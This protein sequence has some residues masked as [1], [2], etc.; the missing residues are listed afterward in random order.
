MKATRVSKVIVMVA[1][2]TL[3]FLTATGMAQDFKIG[4]IY[5]GTGSGAHTGIYAQHGVELAVEEINAKGINGKKL[6]M[7]YENDDT[8]TEKSVTAAKKLIYG[9]K[10][11]ALIGP[12]MSSCI[13]G[14]Q[15]VSEE[16]K[17]PMIS[18]TGSSPKLTEEKQEWYFRNSP[19]ARYQT[20]DLAEYIKNQGIR[21]LGLLVDWGRT[22]DQAQTF[23]EDAKK[24]GLSIAVMEKFQ[25]GDTSFMSQLLK[26]KGEKVDG[27]VFFAMPTEGSAGA[28]QARDLGINVP[29]FGIIAMSYKEYIEMGG[30]AVEGTVLPTTFIPDNPDPAVQKF[31]ERFKAKFN[32]LPDHA[33]AHS[34]DATMILAEVLKKVKLDTK[35]DTLASDRQKIRD[36]FATIKNYRGV[37]VPISYGP[38]PTAADRDGM[39][40]LMLVQVKNGK[41]VIIKK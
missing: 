13:F 20:V 39:K 36:G 15:K 6:D 19:S 9:D 32:V 33:A 4:M 22:S 10:V 31:D 34:Y 35:P 25:T 7:I 38:N 14:V 3:G 29:L 5:S 18:P 24:A 30:K 37:S 23:E 8:S 2:L 28:I 21:K 27:L 1:A 11:L 16:A 26:I 41:W 17:I 40:S 12:E